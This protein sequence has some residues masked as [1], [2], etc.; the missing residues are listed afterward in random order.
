MVQT[1][2]PP[3]SP[4][5]APRCRTLSGAADQAKAKGQGHQPAVG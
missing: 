4:Q 2:I 5:E 1:T 3:Q